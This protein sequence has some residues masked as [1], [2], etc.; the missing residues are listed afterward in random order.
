MRI[1]DTSRSSFRLAQWDWGEWLDNGGQKP[2]DLQK[3]FTTSHV[4]GEEILACQ[5][6]DIHADLQTRGGDP[7]G[8]TEVRL[9]PSVKGG[10]AC[11]PEGVMKEQLNLIPT[12]VRGYIIPLNTLFVRTTKQALASLRVVNGWLAG[13]K[14]KVPPLVSQPCGEAPVT[15]KE[16]KNIQN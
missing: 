5:V 10:R 8:G 11:L 15:W 16:G 13:V 4:D 9:V 2:L 12:K 1:L 3:E 14:W 6:S 7:R